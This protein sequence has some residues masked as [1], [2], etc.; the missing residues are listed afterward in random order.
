MNNVKAK[1]LIEHFDITSK[2]LYE[3]LNLLKWVIKSERRGWVATELGVNKGALQR[4]MRGTDYVIWNSNIKNNSEL[5]NAIK[6]FKETK[7]VKKTNDIDLYKEFKN[8][9]PK[10]LTNKEKKEK[11]DIYERYVAEYFRNN[12]NTVWEHGKEKGVEDGGMDLFVKDGRNIYFVQCKDW[13]KW[14][15]DLNTVQ[16]TQTKIANLLKQYPQWKNIFDGYNQK[17]LFVAP[18]GLEKGAYKYIEENSDE[19]EFRKIEI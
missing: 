16:A 17:I 1:D 13:S 6:G 7:K 12:G 2:K 8:S 15:I 9:K 14:K 11:G 10:K 18:S 4:S 5:I 3:I 19:L